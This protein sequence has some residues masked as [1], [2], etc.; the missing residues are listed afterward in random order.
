MLKR[1]GNAK[2]QRG[3]TLVTHNRIAEVVVVVM[4]AMVA[5][6]MFVVVMVAM[7][8]ARPGN[9]QEHT[10]NTQE[11]DRNL[12]G[13]TDSERRHIGG[14]SGGSKEETQR[15]M[16][17]SEAPDTLNPERKKTFRNAWEA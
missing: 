8:V 11:A 7:G 2:E 12:A 13:N 15:N 3:N 4:V 16:A 5:M 10:G 17:S 1:T 9:R 14:H 6:V